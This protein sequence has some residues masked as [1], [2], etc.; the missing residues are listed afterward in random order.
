[1]I[2]EKEGTPKKPS[3]TAKSPGA[4][5]SFFSDERLK[6]V[7]GI[8]ITGFAFYLLLACVSYLFW[9]KSDLSLAGNDVISGPEIKVKNWAGK[10]GFWLSDMMCN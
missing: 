9:W 6:F 1:M 3:K 7:V 10:S 2:K 5:K 4:L 8:L